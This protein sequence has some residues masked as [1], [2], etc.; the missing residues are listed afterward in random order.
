LHARNNSRLF[1]IP[2]ESFL[3]CTVKAHY[4]V[5]ILRKFLKALFLMTLYLGS[6]HPTGEMPPA[7]TEKEFLAKKSIQL[8]HRPSHS[9][10]P[11]TGDFFPLPNAEE[12]ASEPDLFPGRFQDEVSR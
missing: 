1:H 6:C 9:P 3:Q 11:T 10:L 5:G 2:K 4:I 7:Q 12:S 8:F